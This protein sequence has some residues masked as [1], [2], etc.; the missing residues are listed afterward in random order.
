MRTDNLNNPFFVLLLCIFSVFV[1]IISSIYFFPI[2][3]IGVLFISF[4]ICLKRRHHYS[5]IFIIIT[6]CL[7]EINNGFKLFSLSLLSTFVYVFIAPYIKR[8]LS[9]NSLNPYI[10]IA[11]FYLGVYIMWSLNNNL[12]PQLNYT[13]LINLAIDFFIFG[14]FV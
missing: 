13:L 2:L 12:T 14:V 8:T 3:F 1:N 7:I 9:F 11:V 6:F 5:L 10:Y 4:F